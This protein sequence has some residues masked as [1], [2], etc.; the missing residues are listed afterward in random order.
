MPACLEEPQGVVLNKLDVSRYGFIGP[1]VVSHVHADD[2]LA[3]KRSTVALGSPT[4]PAEQVED[5]GRLA[6]DVS[7]RDLHWGIFH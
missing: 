6:E 3:W 4:T 2:A 7:V 1:A 5:H